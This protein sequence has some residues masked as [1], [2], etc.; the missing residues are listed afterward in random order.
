LQ[1]YSTGYGRIY[2]AAPA[3]GP[4]CAY[5]PRCQVTI[6]GVQSPVDYNV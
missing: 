2:Q 1:A 5:M 6:Q 4:T 3:D